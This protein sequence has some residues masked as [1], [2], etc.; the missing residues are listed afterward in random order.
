M[1][2]LLSA[3]RTH[4][5]LVAALLAASVA[6]ACGAFRFGALT[7][8]LLGW[9]TGV[10]VYLVL[11]GQMM[12]RADHAE[13]KSVAA[14]QAESA[15][16]VLCVGVLAAIVSLLGTVLQ[17]LA[18]KLPGATHSLPHLAFAL[19][20]VAGSWLLVPT[21]FGLSYASAWYSS[22]APQGLKFPDADPAFQPHYADFMYFSITIAA[23]AQTSDVSIV[24]SAMRRLVLAHTIVSF[25]FNT[26]VL[27]FTINVAAS[28]F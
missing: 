22:A 12:L 17:L 4:P 23:A 16:T 24:N 10:W 26:A 11:V 25:V 18:A 15:R 14:A 9:N 19:A 21:L 13:L 8:A 3:I 7:G 1:S 2:S 20:T 6:G 27:A 5:R 28:M